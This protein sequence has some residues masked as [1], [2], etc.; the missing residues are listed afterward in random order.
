MTGMSY[1]LYFV[2]RR[3]E[4]GLPVEQFFNWFRRRKNYT[5]NESQAFYA[6]ESTGVYF[7]FEYFPGNG[8]EEDWN[9]EE[10]GINDVSLLPFSFEINYFRPHVFALEAEPEVAA[11]IRHFDLLV[12]DPQ[13]NGMGYGEYDSTKFLTGW[14][15]GNELACRTSDAAVHTL[16]SKTIRAVWEWNYNRETLIEKYSRFQIAVPR[17]MLIEHKGVVCTAAVWTDGQPVALPVTDVVLLARDQLAPRRLFRKKPDMAIVNRTTVLDSLKRIIRPTDGYYLID[18]EHPDR[19]TEAFI[20]RQE[21]SGDDLRMLAVD[22]VLDK[23]IVKKST[24]IPE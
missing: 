14:N 5:V 10:W 22:H 20:K 4:V 15:M 8:T 12:E 23:E 19:E 18:Y 6:N 16:P 24:M 21:A 13:I 7:A 9:G 3:P 1:D 17:I 11:F 2:P